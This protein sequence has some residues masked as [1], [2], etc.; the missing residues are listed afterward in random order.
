M[1][2]RWNLAKVKSVVSEGHILLHR[3]RARDFFDSTPEAEAFAKRAVALLG[4]RHFV[5]VQV[6]LK[7]E[8][9]VYAVS[10]DGA[11]WYVKLVLD[12]VAPEVAF[13]S[14]HPLERPI[15]TKGGM[16]KP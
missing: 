15:R 5:E 9:D 16:V 3:T 2:A 12:E 8:A 4:E 11:G 10:V 6:L 7:G 1:R 13:I 14:L